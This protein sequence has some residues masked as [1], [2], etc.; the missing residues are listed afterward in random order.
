MLRK[1]NLSAHG[2]RWAV[3]TPVLLLVVAHLTS[4]QAPTL[5]QPPKK[6]AQYQLITKGLLGTVTVPF[7]FKSANLR[8]EIRDL[9]MG[10]R[11]AHIQPVSVR[12]ILEVRGGI[13]IATINGHQQ[14]Y[15]PGDFLI[16]DKDTGLDLQNPRDVTVIRAIYVFENEK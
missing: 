3:L 9:I 11:A 16:V 2:I 10:T 12:T 5:K 8:L 7:Q 6:T 4:E 14:A 13:V 1:A 15:I